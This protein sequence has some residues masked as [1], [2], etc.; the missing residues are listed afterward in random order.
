M[1]NAFEHQFMVPDVVQADVGQL[2]DGLLR[3]LNDLLHIPGLIG[4]D[5]AVP[6][7]VLD[8]PGPDDAGGVGLSVQHA[9]V[10]VEERIDEH[11]ENRTRHMRFG[12][13]DRVGRPPLRD[14][15]HVGDRE[16][17]EFLGH[18][19]LNPRRE[20]SGNED[21]IVGAFGAKLLDNVGEHGPIRHAQQGFGTGMGVGTDPCTLPRQRYYGLHD[22]PSVSPGVA[23][24][25]GVEWTPRPGRTG[26]QAIRP[27]KTRATGQD[28]DSA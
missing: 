20:V 4:E 8:L 21:E 15:L 3:L 2:R 28:G 23:P 1:S 22:E 14:L 12:E 18:P 11:D 13:G 5:D 25:M 27:P 17:G 9:E 6:L 7:V 10:R 16:P 19:G 26:R 24:R